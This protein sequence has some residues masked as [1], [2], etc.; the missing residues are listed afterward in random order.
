VLLQVTLAVKS[1]SSHCYSFSKLSA[2]VVHHKANEGVAWAIRARFKYDTALS[3]VVQAPTAYSLTHS[4]SAVLSG[5]H[6]E[7]LLLNLLRILS[8]NNPVSL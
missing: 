4:S 5:I 8:L 7:A 1:T 3:G 2:A 6:R